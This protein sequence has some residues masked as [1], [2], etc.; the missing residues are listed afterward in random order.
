MKGI[1]TNV[2]VRYMVQ[3]DPTQSK[4]AARFIERE[5]TRE[6]PGFVNRIVLCELVWVLDG[7]YRYPKERIIDALE[8]LLRIDRFMVED[9][10][11]A[12]SALQKYRSGPADFADYLLG[13]LNRRAGCD[14]TVSFDRGA[15]RSGDFTLL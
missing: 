6:S 13:I 4:L 15:C 12:W 3:D 14:S 7:V 10:Q 9:V 1:D 5:C 11:S 8:K 2:L